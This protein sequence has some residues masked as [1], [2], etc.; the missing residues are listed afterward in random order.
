MHMA[1]TSL[2]VAKRMKVSPNRE[3]DRG[4]EA[5]DDTAFFDFLDDAMLLVAQHALPP[6]VYNLCLTNK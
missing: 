4:E 6:D 1:M 2:P 5:T 3:T